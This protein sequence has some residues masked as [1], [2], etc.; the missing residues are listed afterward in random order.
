WSRAPRRRRS[1]PPSRGDPRGDVTSFPEAARHELANVQLRANLRNATDTIRAKRAEVV[2]E[3][4]DWEELRN[5]GKAIKE[6][7]MAQLDRY[8]SSHILVPAIH[9]NRR[10]IRDIFART[11]A[12]GITSDEPADLAEASR[13]YLRERFLDARVGVSGANFG[14]AET[15]AVCIVESEGNG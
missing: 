14:I 5:A 1:P 8:W 9:R 13:S 4:P 15:G 6:D 12:P 10:E 7:V 2:A 11:I 3:L